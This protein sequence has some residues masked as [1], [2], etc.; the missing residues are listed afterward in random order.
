M[1]ITTVNRAIRAWLKRQFGDFRTA[2]GT[3]PVAL[4]HL[5]LKTSAAA[6]SAKISLK[7]HTLI[8]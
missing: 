3:G 5:A 4:N 8:N 6:A 7:G 2:A 1:A